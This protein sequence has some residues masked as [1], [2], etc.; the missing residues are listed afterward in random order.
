METV[1][2]TVEIGRLE[3]V[4]SAA[5]R[6][7]EICAARRVFAIYGAMGAGKTTLVKALCKLL[8]SEDVVKSPTFAIVNEYDSPGGSIFH[9]DFYRIKDLSEVFDIGFEEYITSGN[10]CFLE[11]PELIEPLVPEEAAVLN[12]SVTGA[13]ERMIKIALR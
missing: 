9:F 6:I 13:E 2:A 12:I 7:L 10:Y 4:A 11:W 5:A 3:E 8:G 1:T